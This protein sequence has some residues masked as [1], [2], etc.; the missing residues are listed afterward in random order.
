MSQI[1]SDLLD[2]GGGGGVPGV[3]T[4]QF[5]YN[6]D[7]KKRITIPAGWRHSVQGSQ[8]LYVLPDFDRKCLNVLPAVE[9]AAKL[10]R[11]RKHSLSD[12]NAM[13]FASILG[14]NSEV[15]V[16]DC[17]GRIRISDKLLNFAG[18][19]KQ[20]VLVGAFKLFEL[21]EPEARQE[22]APPDVV[23]QAALREAASSVD[24]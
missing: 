2:R 3:F 4:G 8:S 1:M 5:A 17:Q 10:E 20:V 7:P 13:R 14:A 6:L 19:Q 11:L 23:D 15:V 24:F 16:M 12:K 21:W 22:V 18:L 9:M